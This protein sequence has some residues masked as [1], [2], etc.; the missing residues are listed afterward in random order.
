MVQHLVTPVQVIVLASLDISFSTSQCRPSPAKRS[1]P[2]VCV[3]ET[4]TLHAQHKQSILR[5]TCVFHK[6]LTVNIYSKHSQQ[7]CK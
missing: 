3:Q 5:Y 4:K 6:T 1:L 7:P 2:V